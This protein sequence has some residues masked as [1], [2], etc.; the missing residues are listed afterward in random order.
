[1]PKVTLKRTIEAPVSRVW[2]S[3]NDYANIDKFNPNL[4]RSFLINDN[5]DTGLGATRQCD[6]S[7]GRNYIRERIVDYVPEERLTLDIYDG[8]LPLKRTQAIIEMRPLG[9]S[10]T[11]LSFTMDFTP[12]FGIL[13]RLMVPMMKPQFRKLLGRLVDGNKAYVESGVEIA[14][15]A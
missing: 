5:G 11:E 2:D 8:T 12:K 13:G 15:A 3:W 9:P 4:K 14:R 7:D 6:L 1:M 10:R